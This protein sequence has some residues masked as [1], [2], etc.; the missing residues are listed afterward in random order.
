MTRSLYLINPR[1][2]FQVYY[3]AEIFRYL[4]YKS[5]AFVADLTVTTV[6]ATV[7][8]GFFVDICDE[9]I[10]PVNLDHPADY[11]ALTGKTSQRRTMLG[12]ADEFRRR[13]K[14]VIIGGVRQAGRGSLDVGL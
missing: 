4:G 11:I 5:A 3:G 9:S 12:L 7:P 10:S 6:A 2:D 8:A 1:A 13:G 14:T